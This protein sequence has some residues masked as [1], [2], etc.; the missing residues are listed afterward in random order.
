MHCYTVDECFEQISAY[1]NGENTGY[2]LLVNIDNFDILQSIVLR[3]A[4]D[5]GKQCIYVSKYTQN[6]GLPDISR[7]YP[8]MTNVGEYVLIGVSQ[9][10]MLQSESALEAELDNL[11]GFPIKGKVIILLTH[12]RKYLEKYM[13]RDIRTNNRIVL[14]EST[15]T[16]LPQIKLAA[17]EAL[18]VGFKPLQ[19]I[20]GLL[21]YLECATEAKILRHP[22]LTVLSHFKPALFERSMFFVVPSD[23]VY[24]ALCQKYVDLVTTESKY[25]T[26]KQWRWLME[27]MQN[28]DS[29]S[30][31]ICSVYGS[32]IN[33]I[34]YFG[35]VVSAGNE[36]QTWLL[37]L[38]LKVFGA[39]NNKYLSYVLE[40]NESVDTFTKAVYFSLLDYE[41]DSSDFWS[42]Y[43]ERTRIID[44]LP[45]D[46]A[47]VNSYCNLVGVKE[48]QA[49]Y[50]LTAGTEREE[51]ELMNCLNIYDYSDA[52]LSF[53]FQRAFPELYRYLKIYEFDSTNTKL[54]ESESAFRVSLTNYFQEYKR[55]K[56]VNK[57]N[58][59]FLDVVS[60]YAELRP[61]N[62]LCSRSSIFNGMSKDNTAVYF[63]DALGAEY[64]SYIQSKCEDYGL[65]TEIAIAR[66]ELPSI[67]S[68]NKEFM[69]SFSGVKK[70]SELDELKHHS[71][72][73]DYETCR[74]PIHVFRELDI[75][76]GELKRINAQL[77]QGIVSK[78]VI[79]S[80][81]GASRLAVI[82]EH[83]S[84]SDIELDEKGLHSGR[85]CKTDIDPLLN[86]AAYENGY[87]IIANYERFKGGRKAN[88]EAHG[89]A[90]LEEVVVPII[91]LYRKP[92][93]VKYC[94]TDPVI[95]FKLGKDAQITLF[96]N[97]PMT[98]P[99]LL[100][101]GILYDGTFVGDKKH[102]TFTM[103]ELKRAKEYSAEL[104]EGDKKL[105]VNL[106]FSIERGT[107]E[108]ILF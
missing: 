104:Y 28:T 54:P 32:T 93:D 47:L 91:T 102:A 11:L 26:D 2:P 79:L 94:F 73:Y 98:S 97:V 87:A 56:L 67:T 14:V 108:K 20:K 74:L 80:D 101:N 61:F 45:E 31:Y 82:W 65:I 30:E 71:Q 64:L 57:V 81:H 5:R 55:Q 66:C 62:K 48:K 38:A 18:C 53:V 70:I 63:F 83:E 107:K 43:A 33:L 41:S 36:N 16:M 25:G 46:L 58:D 76:D 22:V 23:S 99:K 37:W 88:L 24:E 92:D 49:I 72:I 84:E 8:L 42:R 12:C 90:T 105:G 75:I 9:A 103:P 44:L 6:N 21:D 40:N 29:F 4:A 68:E 50:Y 52:E 89:G 60:E 7:L 34:S 1:C 85:C 95:K 96:C 39:Q 19:G 3:L 51:Y 15:K 27:Q 78:A 100:V 86:N 35:E 106:T 59:D 10:L 17:D 77:V 69:Q 13:V